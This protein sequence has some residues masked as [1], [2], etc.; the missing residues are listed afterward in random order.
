MGCSSLN[1]DG[2]SKRVVYSESVNKMPTWDEILDALIEEIQ[3]DLANLV[4]EE[5]R[6]DL[7][8]LL[9]VCF[10]TWDE[11]VAKYRRPRCS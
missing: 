10:A 2:V 1:I 4:T 9:A 3:S 8:Q 5:A 11:I 7:Q 6:S